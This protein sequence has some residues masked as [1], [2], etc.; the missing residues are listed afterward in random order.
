VG[1]SAGLHGLEKNL[2]LLPGFEPGILHPVATLP[3]TLSRFECQIKRRRIVA[4]LHMTWQLWGQTD[5]T[6]QQAFTLCSSTNGASS[7]PST[8]ELQEV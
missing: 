7:K 2:V 5:M 3:S 4:E 8:S 6:S 1:P